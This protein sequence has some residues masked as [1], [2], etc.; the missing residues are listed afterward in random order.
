MSGGAGTGERV[1]D[2]S[3][4]FKKEPPKRP[5]VDL[6]AIVE[7]FQWR[8]VERKKTDQ[9][10]VFCERATDFPTAVRRAVESRDENGKH[11]NHQSK[12][13]LGARRTFGRKI[14]RRQ[15]KVQRIAREYGFDA[16]HDLLDEIKPYGI[17]PVTVY[18]VAV[19]IGAY[20]KIEPQSVY[21]HAGVRQGM[22]AFEFAVGLNEDP[23]RW[24][25]RDNYHG[26]KPLYLM[27]R[28]PLSLLP[29]PFNR[30]RADDVEDIL[31][32]YRGVFEEW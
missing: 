5:L 27:P 16:V 19:R 4:A 10:I 31:C 12:V 17:G 11:H 9:V 8:Y 22:K 20:L 24:E 23:D 7:D 30:M 28:V 6:E 32:T 25:H 15:H 14:I 1:V 13:D 21:M 2:A 29:Q 26:Y 18:D 3:K